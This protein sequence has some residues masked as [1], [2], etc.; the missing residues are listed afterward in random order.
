MSTPTDPWPAPPATGPLHATT[1]I[2][3]SKSL[4]NRALPLAALA[5][6]PSVI[7]G[8]LRSRD[9]DLMID[10]LRVLGADIRIDGTTIEVLPGAL[11]GGG[12]IDC[13]LAGTVM[14]FIPPVAALADG[15]VRL[16][17]DEQARSRPMGPVIAGLRSLGVRV[18]GDD[19]PPTHLPVTVHGV[20]AVAGGEIE[21]DASSSSQFVSALLL[22]APRFESGLTLHHI[23]EVL[24]SQPHIDMTIAELRRRGVSVD[25]AAPGKWRVEPGPID[26]GE[27]RIEPDLSNAAPFL[28]AALV[29]GGTVRVPHWPHETTQPGGM[30]PE[31]LAAF[32]ASVSWQEHQPETSTIEVTGHG[33]IRPVD[34]DLSP[35]GELAPTLAALAALV[36]GRSHLRGIAHL[37][38]H[39]TDRLAALAT[40]IQRLGG[41]AEETPDGLIIDGGELQPAVVATYHDHRMATFAAIIG[42]AVPGVEV[43]NLATTAKTLP[44]F[45]RLWAHMLT[46]DP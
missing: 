19:D 35:A 43:V 29:A 30:L 46:G 42:L 11:R 10:A 34:L 41:V 13:G 5:S 26:G 21:I 38:F 7:T 37:R 4:T 8:A 2:P 33:E 39:E 17:G 23:G 25:D 1:P 45:D 12:E 36:P 3:G 44:G 20:G 16:D 14:R 31:Y 15:P 9:A 24:P 6:A 22:A 18:T 40:E 32:G 27:V 28:A